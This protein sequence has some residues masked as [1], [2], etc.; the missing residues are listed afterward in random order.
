MMQEDTRRASLASI[1]G[2][3]PDDIEVSATSLSKP[4]ADRI[5]ASK[6]MPVL[7]SPSYFTEALPEDGGSAS[8]EDSVQRGGPTR[9]ARSFAAL[10]PGVGRPGFKSTQSLPAGGGK[11]VNARPPLPLGM[12]RELSSTP[13]S[14]QVQ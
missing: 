11:D 2:P 8:E 6:T 12:L 13:R 4:D 1:F 5:S 14:P 7:R 3:S 10:F 9:G